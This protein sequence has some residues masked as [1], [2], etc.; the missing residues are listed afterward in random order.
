MI[1]NKTQRLDCQLLDEWAR[2]HLNELEFIC[3]KLPISLIKPFRHLPKKRLTVLAKKNNTMLVAKFFYG[4]WFRKYFEREKA[5]CERLS[6]TTVSSPEVLDAYV[7]DHNQV[8]VILFQYLENA[9]TLKSA[10]DQAEATDQQLVLSKAVQQFARLH[11]AGLIQEDPHLDNM[12]SSGDGI[13]L[14]DAG[15][16]VSDSSNNTE[17][18]KLENLALFLSQLPV[19]MDCLAFE[20]TQD[21]QKERGLSSFPDE[22]EWSNLIHQKR[23]WRIKRF[24]NRKVFRTC[25]AFYSRKSFRKFLVVDREVCTDQMVRALEVPDRLFEGARYLKKGRTAT[26]AMINLAGND[27]VLKRY[28][29]KKPVHA[30]IRGLKWS[31]AAES[32]RN[33]HILGLLGIPTAKPVAL[34]EERYGLLRRRSYLLAEVV[35][36]ANIIDCFNDPNLRESQK[37]ELAERLK[38]LFAILKKGRV[39]HGDCKGYNILVNTGGVVLIDLDGMRF[40]EEDGALDKLHQKDWNRFMRDIRELTQYSGL[41]DR[42]AHQ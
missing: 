18:R 29:I 16:I 2:C 14:V 39:I 27:Y 17:A 11:E 22:T 34:V 7:D 37:R 40:L 28:N 26:V 15:G 6:G 23:A 21:Y 33:G 12:M 42:D 4:E 35:D 24:V 41:F 3:G 5:S 10:L 8:A 19:G 9:I 32:W 1:G 38:I 25:S 31:R 20:A 36:G 13:Y 30:L